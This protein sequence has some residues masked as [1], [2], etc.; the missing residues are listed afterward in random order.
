MELGNWHIES[1]DQNSQLWNSPNKVM[2]ECNNRKIAEIQLIPGDKL[3]IYSQS[4]ALFIDETEKH[5]LVSPH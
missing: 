5:I 3:M 2:I 4:C 1:N